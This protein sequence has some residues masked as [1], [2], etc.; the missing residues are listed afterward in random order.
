ML[1]LVAVDTS[2][3]INPNACVWL[4]VVTEFVVSFVML[5]GVPSVSVRFA[6]RS[7]PPVSPLPAAML[8]ASG[9]IPSPS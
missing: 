7:P 5:P 4:V 6:E 1:A 9:V 3:A 8:R 2:A